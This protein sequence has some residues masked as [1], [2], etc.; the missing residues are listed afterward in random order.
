M[1]ASDFSARIDADLPAGTECAVI[2]VNKATATIEV[3]TA[4]D[5]IDLINVLLSALEGCG[6][7][8]MVIPAPSD[9]TVN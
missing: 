9:S 1:Q 7:K 2:L 3:G 5:D 8:A 6:F 4:L